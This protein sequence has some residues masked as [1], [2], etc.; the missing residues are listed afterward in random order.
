MQEKLIAITFSLLILGQAWLVRRHVGT[1]IFPACILGLFWFGATFFPLV[2]L[3]SV[4]V[5]P[6]AIAFIL[7]ACLLFSGTALVFNWGEAYRTNKV[8]DLAASYDTRFLWLSFY[9]LSWLVVLSIIINWTLQGFSLREIAFDLFSTANRYL[10]RR[11]AGQISRNIV[12]QIGV[13][14]TYP[15]AILGGVVYAA[16]R[17]RWDG[18]L[19]IVI[20]FL[21][22]V[23]VMV[24][25]GNKGTLFLVAAL[26]WAGILVNGISKGDNHLLGK[27]TL[28]KVAVGAAV[29]LPLLITAFWIRIIKV[30]GDFDQ[31]MVKMLWYFY[32]YTCGHLYAFSDWF[33]ALIGKGA[34]QVYSNDFG[35]HGFYT[36]MGLFRA[37]GDTRVVPQGIYSEY[38]IYKDVLQSNIY[39]VFRGL[40]QDFGLYGAL[41]FWVV[42]GFIAH[43]FFRWLLLGRRQAMAI[44]VFAHF[45]GFVYSSFI[46][47]FFVWNSIY[48]S[49]FVTVVI[50]QMN[51]WI[52]TRNMGVVS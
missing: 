13:V 37:L 19:T 36:F 6:L 5:E 47:S 41:L 38:F 26:F 33:A 17:N 9:S 20:A 24:V 21:A 42:A 25:E 12:S 29:L 49:I 32:S 30:D 7:G 28:L 51:Y 1:W 46:V 22:S 48:A 39:T 18:L 44:S 4:P 40:V 10:E 34:A 3:F 11:Y 43:I 45:V 23:L 15:A 14:L 31:T 8:V 27:N 16:R 50:F 2:I 52:R 35:A